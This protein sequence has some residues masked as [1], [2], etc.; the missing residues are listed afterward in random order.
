MP[1][2]DDTFVLIGILFGMALYNKCHVP[3]PFPTALFKKM[4][5]IAPT[6]ED[7]K[8]LMPAVGRYKLRVS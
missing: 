1:S 7:L 2:H 6:L 4:L 8:E 3:F 5:N